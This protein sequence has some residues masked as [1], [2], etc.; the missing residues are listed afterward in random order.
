MPQ[1]LK[2]KV[3]LKFSERFDE[4]TNNTIQERI[5]D[6]VSKVRTQL[7][8]KDPIRIENAKERIQNSVVESQKNNIENLI[9]LY[10]DS[11]AYAEQLEKGRHNQAPSKLH[12][13]YLKNYI[14]EKTGETIKFPN[15][16]KDEEGKFANVNYRGTIINYKLVNILNKFHKNYV[17]DFQNYYLSNY[18]GDEMIMIIDGK[19]STKFRSD[20]K[21][22]VK[23]ITLNHLNINVMDVEEF[24][25]W[26]EKN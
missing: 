21:A 15:L 11:D 23:E 3:M 17:K 7:N 6:K 19:E 14:L 1:I 9:K 18:S 10:L 13:L 25:E 26:I 2:I 16:K 24:I 8:S 22:A 20:M 5:E 12:H 4:Y